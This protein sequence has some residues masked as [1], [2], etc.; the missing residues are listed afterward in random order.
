MRLILVTNGLGYG[1]AERVVEALA[2]DLA[3][4]G[5]HVT[6][7]ATTRDGPVGEALRA[8]GIPVTVLG[9]R[10][11]AD[12]RVPV[13]LARVALARGAELIHSHLAV[14]DIAT[15][16]AG[17]A[18]PGVARV[19]TVH[20]RGVELDRLKLRLWHR[21][22]TRFQRVL[23]VSE[24]VQDSLP[25]GL[26]T[27]ILRPSLIDPAA[28]RPSRE[29]ARAAL[30][31]PMGAPL[32][33]AVG[34]LVPVKGF[35]VLARAAKRLTTPGARVVVIGEGPE[36]ARLAQLGGLELIGAR[37]DVDA[38]LPAADVVV[39]P[40]RSEGFP[41]VPL[42]AMAAGLP[43]VATPVG[44][45]PEIVIPEV[46]GALVPPE[47]P[48]ALAQALDRLLADR[49]AAQALGAAGRARLVEAGLTRAAMVART[50]AVYQAVLTE[51]AGG[52]RWPRRG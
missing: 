18:L 7:V 25:P 28:P 1:G 34:R 23:A 31:V 14:A 38:L 9:I 51:G 5:D 42:H 4:Q 46:T 3:A 35:D 43:V 6:V 32:V 49:G 33:V 48:R 10:S 30:K 15:A 12:A 47:D 41:Q 11:P 29:A 19:T 52:P 50:R 36:R 22:L 16:A 26:P 17:L 24:A 37:D 21:A 13:A 20:N 2:R 8:A 39:C 45:T 44:G 40:S 27:E